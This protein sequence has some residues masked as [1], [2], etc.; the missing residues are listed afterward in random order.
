MLMAERKTLLDPVFI[1]GVNM[2]T[3]SQRPTTFGT[4]GLHQVAPTGAQTQD[5]A[6]GSNFEPLG[7][8]FFGFN[9]FR[10]SHMLLRFL[11]K[12]RAI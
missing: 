9:A 3:A 11:S 8:R 2:S 1:R 6:T 5:F 7:G 12:E 10:T 4:F